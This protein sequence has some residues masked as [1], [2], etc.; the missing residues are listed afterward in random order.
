MSKRSSKKSD[1][2]ITDIGSTAGFAA[3]FAALMQAHGVKQERIAAY[4][5]VARNTVSDWGNGAVPRPRTAQA[6]ADIFGVNAGWL[7]YGTGAKL[8]PG[9]S[10][11]IVKGLVVPGT[12]DS[13]LPEESAKPY[14]DGMTPALMRQIAVALSQAAAALKVC[15]QLF[16]QAAKQEDR[17]N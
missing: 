11:E 4:L 6:L 2:I 7:I 3:R 16:A 9:R 17:R 13:P 1:Q 15:S 12:F 10:E 8:P 14:E 5:G